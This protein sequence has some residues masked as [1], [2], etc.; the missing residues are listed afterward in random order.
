ML[1]LP[2]LEEAFYIET[3]IIENVS[4]DF[5]FQYNPR[6]EAWYLGLGLTGR[7][8]KARFKLRTNSDVLRPY[9]IFDEIPNGYIYVID[10]VAQNGRLN[11]DDFVDNGR[12]ALVYLTEAEYN[13]FIQ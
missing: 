6:E 7:D 5:L 3:L 13:A 2:L 8:P 11:R 9:R 10:T 12:F 1:F 4:Y